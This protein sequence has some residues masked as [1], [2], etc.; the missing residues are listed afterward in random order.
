MKKKFDCV[1][2]KWDIQ[3][4]LAKEYTGLSRE[5]ISKK[6]IRKI[7]NNPILG[8]YLKTSVSIAG[9]SS[10]EPTHA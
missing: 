5:E 8:K 10:K 4:K 1:Q 6:Q 2:M 9:V 3:K 7:R